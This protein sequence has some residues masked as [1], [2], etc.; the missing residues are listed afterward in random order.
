M[1][2]SDLGMPAESE[3]TLKYDLCMN[4]LE[5]NVW[6]YECFVHATGV[7]IPFAVYFFYDPRINEIDDLICHCC[8]CVCESPTSD[9]DNTHRCCAVGA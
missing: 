1:S 6:D 9:D 8:E 2:N 5:F 3:H 4:F 7:D